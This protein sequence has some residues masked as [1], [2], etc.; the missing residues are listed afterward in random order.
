MKHELWKLGWNQ[1]AYPSRKM[2]HSWQL[3]ETLSYCP[4]P[5]Q[6][7]C[8]HPAAKGLDPEQSDWRSRKKHNLS[9]PMVR[10]WCAKW[11]FPTLLLY[12][13]YLLGPA[14]HKNSETWRKLTGGNFSVFFLQDVINTHNCAETR[15][16]ELA[17]NMCMGNAQRTL[18]V[19]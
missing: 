15:K 5:R 10:Q 18:I 13:L 14:S 6:R 9:A 4:P 12:R 1:V 16:R 11:P 8:S 3:V 17:N 7:S 2:P 19:S